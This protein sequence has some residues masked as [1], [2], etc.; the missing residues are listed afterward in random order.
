MSTIIPNFRI[1]TGTNFLLI[2]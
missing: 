1:L 2:Y